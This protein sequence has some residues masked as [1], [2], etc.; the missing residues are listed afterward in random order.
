[1]RYASVIAIATCSLFILGLEA[2]PSHAQKTFTFLNVKAG[3]C[4]MQSGV[5]T[6]QPD[7]K[8]SWEAEVNSRDQNDAYCVRFSFYGQK[9]NQVFKWPRFCSQ[10]LGPPPYYGLWLRTNL[11]VPASLFAPITTVRMAKSC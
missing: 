6:M 8:V 10:T 9:G 11:A 2:Q 7:G 3:D 1:M 4:R 5:L